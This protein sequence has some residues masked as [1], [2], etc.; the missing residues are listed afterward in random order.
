MEEDG[1]ARPSRALYGGSEP[2][3]PSA[4]LPFPRSPCRYVRLQQNG[5]GV[6]GIDS[7]TSLGTTTFYNDINQLITSWDVFANIG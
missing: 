3:L 4:R 7:F 5:S 6:V 1:R 2:C